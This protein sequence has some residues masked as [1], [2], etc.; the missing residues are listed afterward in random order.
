MV[1]AGPVSGPG[2]PL[3]CQAPALVMC[4]SSVS[5]LPA[6]L[7]LF[8]YGSTDLSIAPKLNLQ[9]PGLGMC[10]SSFSSSEGRLPSVG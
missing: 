9:S 2:M 5:L 10:S 3:T 6:L 1:T 4:Q 8:L 7:S